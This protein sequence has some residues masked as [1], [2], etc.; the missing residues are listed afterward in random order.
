MFDLSLTTH[1]VSEILGVTKTTLY[2]WRRAGKGPA[3]VKDGDDENSRIYYPYQDLQA[4]IAD[5]TDTEK[6]TS[7]RYNHRRAA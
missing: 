3:F 7:T 1:Q 4:W 6:V 5:H 2:M